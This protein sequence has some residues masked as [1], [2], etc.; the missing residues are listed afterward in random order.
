[1]I[2]EINGVNVLPYVQDSGFEWQ[3]N[4]LDGPN[5]GRALNGT[6]IRDRVGIKAT[7]KIT[8][9]PLTAPQLATILTLI[10][11][12]WVQ[13]R[14]TDPTTNSTVTKTMYSNNVP[15]TLRRTDGAVDLWSG[16]SFPLIER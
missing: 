14:Y 8:C 3:R 15:A 9:R 11:P 7:L 10:E 4:D 2:F 16:L 6:L 12:E 1:M 13:V 5:A